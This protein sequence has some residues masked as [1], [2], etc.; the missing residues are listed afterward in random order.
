MQEHVLVNGEAI[1]MFRQDCQLTQDALARRCGYQPR[2]LQKIE[3]G[4][5][6]HSLAAAIIDLAHKFYNAN[7]HLP[8]PQFIV[9]D[10][11][12]Q[13]EKEEKFPERSCASDKAPDAPSRVRK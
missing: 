1:R 2:A 12:A 5:S 9:S 4:D 8:R 3:K 6:E 7:P 13:A 10:P 11:P